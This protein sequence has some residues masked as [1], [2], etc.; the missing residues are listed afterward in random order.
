VAKTEQIENFLHNQLLHL[1]HSTTH[2]KSNAKKMKQY[3]TKAAKD[4]EA[5]L[6]Y[7]TMVEDMEDEQAVELEICG[8]G[9]E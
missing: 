9:S 4:A 7:T 5:I 8:Q 3:T 2:M 6:Q 1:K